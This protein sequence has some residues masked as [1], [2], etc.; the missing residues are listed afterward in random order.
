MLI[1]DSASHARDLVLAHGWNA[2]AY[3]ILNPGITHWFSRDGDAVVGFVRQA[4]TRVVAGAPVCSEARLPDVVRE[5]SASAQAARERVCYFG[6]GDRLERLLIPTGQWSAASLGAQPSWDPHRWPGILERRA[7]LRAQLNRA[8]NKGVMVTEW[9]AAR[10]RGATELR[11]C[12][13]EWLANRHLPP[14]HFLVE[15]DTLSRLEDRRV[16]VASS[17]A[18]VRGFLVASPIPAR[19]GWLVEQ[20]IRGHRAPNGTA[21]LLLDAAMRALAAPG[22]SYVTLGLAPLSRHSHFDRRRMPLWLRVGLTWLRAHGRRFYNFEGLDRFK[23]KFEPDQWEEIVALSDSP[24]FPMRALW[25]IAAAF[26][27]GSPVALVS[28]AL[29]RA[30]TQELS[31]LRR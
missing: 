30:A 12:L 6:A 21:E 28:R 2:T 17:G 5:F 3:Q 10:T 29:G 31:R 25:A 27:R 14:L 18:R 1:S 13:A 19:N 26:S 4:G 16:F 22:V 8:R 7:S 11:T 9:D 20:I 23:A 24:R 15:P